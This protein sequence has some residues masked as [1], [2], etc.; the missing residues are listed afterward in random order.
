MTLSKLKRIIRVAN[1]LPPFHPLPDLDSIVYERLKNQDEVIPL[2]MPLSDLPEEF[3]SELAAYITELLQDWPEFYDRLSEMQSDSPVAFLE[4]Y[5]ELLKDQH[6]AFFLLGR[7]VSEHDKTYFPLFS[8]YPGGDFLTPSALRF[9]EGKVHIE[10][11]NILEAIEGIEVARLRLCRHCG[12]FFYE[13]RIDKEFC[14]NTCRLDFYREKDEDDETR[15]RRN[16]A[17]RDKRARRGLKQMRL[18]HEAERKM[19]WPDFET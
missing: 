18:D 2:A 12:N 19:K 13:G 16:K 1:T 6:A 7:I 9:E 5:G 17:R 8:V 4:N 10:R 15:E 3:V 11:F 14:R